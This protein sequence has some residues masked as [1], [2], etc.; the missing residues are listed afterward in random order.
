MLK[1]KQILE[2]EHWLGEH[3][4]EDIE[5]MIA[6]MSGSGRG[7]SMPPAKFLD[8]VRGNSLR[9]PDAVFGMTITGDY[10]NNDHIPFIERDVMLVPD[11]ETLCVV[12]WQ[13]EPT[14]TVICDPFDANG[15]P[16]PLPPVM[17]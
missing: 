2:L 6:D 4:I 8:S 14:A 15:K 17:P 7:K 5:C 11:L 10:I 16:F 13:S 12:P 9:L 3:R 1:E